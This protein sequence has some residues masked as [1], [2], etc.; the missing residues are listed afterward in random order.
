[1]QRRKVLTD[2]FART[3]HSHVLGQL[4]SY[5]AISTREVAPGPSH[6]RD[7]N[8]GPIPSRPRF[9]LIALIDRQVIRS[10]VCGQPTFKHSLKDVGRFPRPVQHR[11][12]GRNRTSSCTRA[13]GVAPSLDALIH[14]VFHLLPAQKARGAD[15]R[16][17]N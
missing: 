3:N 14:T 13:C 2:C 9:A 10:P 16:K 8:L 6:S 7:I 4:D 1:M 12:T 5:T 17:C 11:V 15:C